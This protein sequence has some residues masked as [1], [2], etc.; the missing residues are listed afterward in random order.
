[1]KNT[2]YSLLVLLA[3]GGAW[4]ALLLM[5][6]WMEMTTGGHDGGWKFGLLAAVLLV[7]AF[8]LLQEALLN[9]LGEKRS[10]GVHDT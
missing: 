5:N 1:M 9:L 6:R 7:L 8:L 10:R 2:W 3:I 4:R